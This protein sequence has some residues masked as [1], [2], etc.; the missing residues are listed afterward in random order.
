MPRPGR[1]TSSVRLAVFSARCASSPC[2]ALA[3]RFLAATSR[4]YQRTQGRG[5]LRRGKRATSRLPRASGR[6]EETLFAPP[7]Q[8]YNRAVDVFSKMED[9]VTESAL[10]STD[11]GAAI[12]LREMAYS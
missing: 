1:S 12:S 4:D 9:A 2:R 11:V 7:G 5:K 3:E 10:L 6:P 8:R